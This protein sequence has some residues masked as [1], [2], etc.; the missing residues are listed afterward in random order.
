[1]V[2]W[3]R[4]NDRSDEGIV[5]TEHFS[6][7]LLPACALLLT[8]ALLFL[9]FARPSY[10]AS[11]TYVAGLL[12][13]EILVLAVYLYR[14]IFFPFVIVTF[15]LAGMDLP[16]G[17]GWNVARWI[18][19][20]V[21]A[22][23]GLLIKFKDGH[24]NFGLF[25]I[26]ALF[27][28]LAALASVAVSRYASFSFLKV[29]SLF[30]L[31]VY[32]G[33]GARLAVAG[34]ERRFFSGLV[35]SCEI[36]VGLIALGYIYGLEV[37]GNRNSLG[38]VMG[39]AVAPILLWGTLI[40]EERSVRRR[41]AFL[42]AVCASLVVASYARAGIV[43]GFMVCGLL[44]MALRKYRLLIQ[45]ITVIV[46]VATAF[47]IVHPEAYSRTVSSVTNK[48]LFKGKDPAGGLL[49]SRHSPWQ[50]AIET[51]QNHQWFGTGFGISETGK[52]ET[53]HLGNFSTSAAASKEFGSSYLAI[54]TWV[55]LLGV[56]PFF[57]LLLVL[58]KTI[59]QTV[60]WMFRTQNPF[61]PAVPLAMVTLAGL[62]H[63][64]FEDWLFAPGFHLA[65]FYWSMAFILV[66]YA[67]KV[68]QPNL[69]RVLS[70][71]SFIPSNQ[72]SVAPSR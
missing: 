24:R 51:I 8:V 52:D 57:M 14:R 25:H 33:T 30:L 64:G 60:I 69:R 62:I 44:C 36:F 40:T 4:E 50:D 1:M 43:A 67:P 49:A 34:R 3:D 5:V 70:R 42:F 53:D 16:I 47:A 72:P 19:L 20:G 41:R 71:N 10:F 17:S 54:T 28:V 9:A 59:V 35:I 63:A 48:V 58:F 68:A 18:T 38:A 37:M 66:D 61:H 31:F 56:L 11:Q 65:V 7:F 2:E 32:A 22:L 55:G 15:L 21:G 45:G 12:F 23:V 13:L 46:I 29:L 39:V 27:S 26:L 6:K